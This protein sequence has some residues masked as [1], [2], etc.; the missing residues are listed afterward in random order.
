MAT[1]LSKMPEIGTT[2]GF[3]IPGIAYHVTPLN[4]RTMLDF[5]TPVGKA[6]GVLTGYFFYL[7]KRGFKE[8]HKIE[9]WMEISPV[10]AQYYQLT[11]QQKQQLERQIKEGLA[12][13]TQAVADLELLM[14]DLRKYKEYM[15]YYHDIEKAKALIKA[16]KKEEGEKLLAKTEQTLKAIFIDQVD[17]HT[18]EGIALK[19][20]APRWPTIIADFMRLKDEDTEPKAIAKKYKV[21]EAEGVVLATKNKLYQKWKEMFK[22]TVTGRYERIKGLVEARKKSVDEYRNM[23]RPYVTRYRS[24]REFGETSE[25]RK[26]LEKTAFYRRGAQAVS[27]DYTMTWAWRSFTPPDFFKAPMEA[28]AGESVNPLRL[29]IAS[30]FK[31]MIKKNWEDVKNAGL[32]ESPTSPTGIE[33]LDDFVFQHYKK[34]EDQY[35]I[36]FSIV[37]ILEERKA[38]CERGWH[39]PYFEAIEVGALRSVFRMPDGSQFEDLVLNPFCCYFDTQNVIILRRLEVR[40]KQIELENYITTMLGESSPEGKKIKDLLKEEYPKLFGGE[41]K[42]PT[43][44]KEEKKAF[45]ELSKAL[46]KIGLDIAFF[47]P[48]PYETHFEDRITGIWFPEIASSIYGP[49]VTLL[50]AALGVPGFRSPT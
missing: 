16:G 5:T 36:K 27:I 37:D 41:E 50:K 17:V 24:I 9:D 19:L 30:G 47:K 32:H 4:L 49:S 3:I 28:R 34:I 42:K 45:A 23:L 31:R 7:G 33:P 29:P 40:A 25:G 8:I 26:L 20:I 14:H 2:K 13:I 11:I 22:E 10:H 46:K 43:E 6:S 48:G 39:S 18:G 44:E 35:K 1:V 21:S 15:D 38:F 12:S